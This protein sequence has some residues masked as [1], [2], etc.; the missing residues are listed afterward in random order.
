MSNNRPNNLIDVCS[1]PSHYRDS[2]FKTFIGIT[3]Q[4]HSFTKTNTP[5]QTHMYQQHS[6]NHSLEANTFWKWWYVFGYCRNSRKQCTLYRICNILCEIGALSLMIYV[7]HMYI[8]ICIHIH[9]DKYS[10]HILVQ[11]VASNIYTFNVFTTISNAL[12]RTT[13]V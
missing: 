11:I 13:Q 3:V 2:R 10:T 7:E 8:H 1:T 5:I 9:V 6:Q 4:E 12:G